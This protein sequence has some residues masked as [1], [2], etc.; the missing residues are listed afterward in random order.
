M[1][2]KNDLRVQRTGTVINNVSKRQEKA[3]DKAVLRLMD[4]VEQEFPNIRIIHES[5]V[6]LKDVTAHIKQSFPEVDT[7]YYFD[8][9]FMTPDGGFVYLRGKDGNRY[10][11]LISEK[12]NQGTNDIRL[13]EGKKK[14]AKGNAIERLGKNVIGL[15]AMMA[16]EDIFPFV[17]FGDG[18]DFDETSS[19]LDR[20]VIIAI[21]GKLNTVY[22]HDVANLPQFK[23]GTYYFRVEEWTEEEMFQR[24]LDIARRSIFYY[25]SKYGEDNFI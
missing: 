17:C 10:P 25:F 15:R 7:F 23:R 20:V 21:F 13:L 6:Y 12:K 1:A 4:A 24:C 18:C 5:R 3:L 22:L 2:R 8:E 16:D 19:I 14:Q 9:S 11:I